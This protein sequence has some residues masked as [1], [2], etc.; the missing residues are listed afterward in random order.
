[1]T[2]ISPE[3]MKVFAPF[4]QSI[5]GIQLDAGKAYLLETRLAAWMKE[6]GCSTFS[7]L[8]YQI[9]ADGSRK[10]QR[11]LIDLISTNAGNMDSSDESEAINRHFRNTLLFIQH[12]KQ[13]D[14]S[15]PPYDEIQIS[16]LDKFNR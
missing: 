12:K 4:I 13:K 9:R 14:T 16:A 6:L 10:M 7:E 11:K 5:C 8:Y 1:M 15:G 2:A 3:E